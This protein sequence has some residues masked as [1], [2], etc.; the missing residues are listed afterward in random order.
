MKGKITKAVTVLVS[1]LLVA[2]IAVGCGPTP[3]GFNKTTG[4]GW[5]I[6]ESTGSKITF[7]FTAQP[8]G[9]GTAKGQFQLVD[10]GTNQHVHG[11]F[12]TTAT[13]VGEPGLTCFS[14]IYSM[15][16]VEYPVTAWFFDGGEGKSGTGD[17][18][19]ITVGANTYIG[20]G[21]IQVHKE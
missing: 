20:K 16:G 14:G 21:N 15:D 4:G 3:T 18:V 11:V 7:G 10:H 19:G 13:Q 8:M 6:D 5:L 9:D 12:T 2:L 17:K 1:L